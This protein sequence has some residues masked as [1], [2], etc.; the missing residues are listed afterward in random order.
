[1]IQKVDNT[2]KLI[3][4]I[5]KK[6]TSRR[7]IHACKKAG[8]EGGT[9]FHGRGTDKRHKKSFFGIMIEPEKD[10]VLCLSPDHLVDDVLEEVTAAAKLDKPGTGVAF[11]INSRGVTGISHLLKS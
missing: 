9:V 3:I 7:V 10:I 1:M 5:V 11:V 6:G 2:Y 4:I 8:A